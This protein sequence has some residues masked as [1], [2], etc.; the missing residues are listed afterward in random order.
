[1]A[2]RA[3]HVLV[4]DGFA[5]WEPAHA[6][7]ELRRAGK[8]AVTVV[9]FDTKWVVSMG[10]LRILP[11]RALADVRADDVELLILPG[12]TVWET[13]G[14]Y[15]REALEQLVTALLA[16]KAPVAAICGATLA[17]ARAGLL[18]DRRHTS[19]APSYLSD[20][21]SEYTGASKY[22]AAPAVSDRGVITASGLGAVDF[23]RAIFSEL[24][25][26]SAADEQRWY[27]LYKH[28][29]TAAPPS[30]RRTPGGEEPANQAMHEPAP[31][32]THPLAHQSARAAR[33]AARRAGLDHTAPHVAPDA[34]SDAPSSAPSSA[35]DHLPRDE[36]A[37]ELA[38]EAPGA[39][40]ESGAGGA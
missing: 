22:D 32:S 37:S 17:L 29:S 27:D 20:H 13:D 23:A 39:D 7:A 24:R 28:G 34:P 11:D 38:G 5:D 21:A 3:V 9:G 10:G 18:N 4:F 15:P 8:R 2:P 36:P 26:F 6:L 16:A 35:P 40:E 14:A 12:G 19:N 25:I 31:D 1:M 33:R 30:E